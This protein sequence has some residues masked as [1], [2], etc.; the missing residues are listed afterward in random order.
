MLIRL[1]LGSA[2]GVDRV[3]ISRIHCTSIHCNHRLFESFSDLP[4]KRSP[5]IK[6]LLVSMSRFTDRSA[7]N[8][9]LRCSSPDSDR[10]PI[11]NGRSRQGR[12]R[13]APR[14]VSCSASSGARRLASAVRR[15]PRSSSPSC[16]GDRMQARNLAPRDRTRPIPQ[17][18]PGHREALPFRPGAPSTSWPSDEASAR[19]PACAPPPEGTAR[20]NH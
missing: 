1:C 18:D 7:E 16:V 5:Q 6:K 3:S 20:F 11:G 8:A 14:P 19:S 9:Q 4:R 13:A 12:F 10:T 2:V 17:P 15:G